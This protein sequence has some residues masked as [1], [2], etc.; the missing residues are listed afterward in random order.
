MMY[1]R[2]NQVIEPVKSQKQMLNQPATQQ[3]N[4]FYNQKNNF[5]RWCEIDE[6][7][8]LNRIETPRTHKGCQQYKWL[9]IGS[10]REAET[11]IGKRKDFGLGTSQQNNV[12][13]TRQIS[14]TNWLFTLLNIK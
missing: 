13:K 3:G 10:N 14:E 2:V 1:E 5:C 9:G 8:T 6:I 4:K 11:V 12:D 7:I